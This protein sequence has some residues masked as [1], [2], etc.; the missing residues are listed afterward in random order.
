MEFAASGK[1]RSAGEVMGTEKGGLT[2]VA[3]SSTGRQDSLF[4][5]LLLR[6]GAQLEQGTPSRTHL[7]LRQH[8]ELLQ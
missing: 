5:H 1:E 4:S 8:P 6:P 7:Q 3:G 2:W